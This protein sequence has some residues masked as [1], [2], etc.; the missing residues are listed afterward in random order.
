VVVA[1]VFDTAVEVSLFAHAGNG[2]AYPAEVAEEAEEQHVAHKGHG[3]EEQE[4][5]EEWFHR[6]VRTGNR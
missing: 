3:K 5:A 4:A 2:G 1:D 6:R